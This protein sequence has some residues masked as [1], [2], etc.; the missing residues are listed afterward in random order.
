MELLSVIRRWRY[1]DHFSIR[2]SSRRTGLSR[3]T[4]CTYLR[5]DN[6]EQ[7]LP[8]RASEL[9]PFADTLSQMFLHE[10]SKSRR[11][12]QTIK[13]LTLTMW[14]SA[15]AA[16][17]I[18]WTL[19]RAWRAARHWERKTTGRDAFVPLVFSPGEAFQFDL[20]E[21]WAGE[22]TRLQVAHFKLAYGRAFILRAPLQQTHEMQFDAH[23]HAFHVLGAVPRRG[24]DDNMRT[25][26]DRGKE[27]KVNARFSAMVSHFLFEAEFCNPALARRR[28]KSRR[29]FRTPATGSN[30]QRR[31]FP[32]WR[33]STTGCSL[34]PK[35]ILPDV[36]PYG[37]M[38]D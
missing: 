19:A 16:R 37:L 17:T 8:E 28:D 22:R 34:T 30:S 38:E 10:A 13:Q 1:R 21:D 14:P 2:E 32:P 26:V 4:V 9:N 27:R 24:I 35:V 11:Q 12:K 5:S 7:K 36:W 18:K 29:T 33:R 25:A 3:N 15:T 31:T 20:S 6:V 23:N